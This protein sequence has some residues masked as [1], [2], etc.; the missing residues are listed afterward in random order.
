MKMNMGKADKL[1]RI[2][3]ALVVILLY[4]ANIISGTVA[5]VLLAFAGIFILTSVVGFCPLYALFGISTC[6]VEQK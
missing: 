4:A 5:L 1:V 3:A 6:K 2:A